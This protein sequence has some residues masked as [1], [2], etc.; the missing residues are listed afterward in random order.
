VE[1]FE[2]LDDCLTIGLH[3]T[4]QDVSDLFFYSAMVS[5]CL[6]L[7]RLQSLLVYRH[8]QSDHKAILDCT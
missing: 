1:L 5:L 4:A 3:R 6:S 2:A 7:K 8:S